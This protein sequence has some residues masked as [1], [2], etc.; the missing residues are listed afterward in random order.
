MSEHQEIIAYQTDP[1]PET[2]EGLDTMK[3]GKHKLVI[4]HGLYK[5][6]WYC[7]GDHHLNDLITT[8]TDAGINFK[9][10]RADA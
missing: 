8:L 5:S 9:L 3:D 10:Y 2:Y 4:Y 7:S 6:L 1:Y